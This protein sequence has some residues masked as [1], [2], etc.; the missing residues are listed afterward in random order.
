[1]MRFNLLAITLLALISTIFGRE[2]SLRFLS[3]ADINGVPVPVYSMVWSA[4]SYT[5]TGKEQKTFFFA[6][7]FSFNTIMT[8]N[9][10]TKS[11][12]FD[13]KTYK[14]DMANFK[15]VTDSVASVAKSWW[16][17][18]V[19]FSD[20]VSKPDVDK[21]QQIDLNLNLNDA[22]YTVERIKLYQNQTFRDVQVKLVKVGD[23]FKNALYV[24]FDFDKKSAG[25][26]IQAFV[27]FLT[28][29]FPNAK[30][31]Q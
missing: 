21:Y 14:N 2:E 22:E 4:K 30:I 23:K 6:A 24:T 18:F 27:A 19:T 8:I 1:M 31:D 20:G 13:F 29:S 11:I 15:Y 28:T 9:T 12:N 26:N 5:T 17:Q 25:E 10:L 3:G 7:P 16:G